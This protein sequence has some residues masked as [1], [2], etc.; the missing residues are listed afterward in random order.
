[1]SSE[2]LNI[3]RG[4]VSMAT[5]KVGTSD[6]LFRQIGHLSQDIRGGDQASRGAG[7][8]AKKKYVAVSELSRQLPLEHEVG[9]CPI[10]QVEQQDVRVEEKARLMPAHFGHKGPQRIH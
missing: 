7:S 1:M 10:H 3:E 4:K 5:P 9:V 6:A 8:C 2:Q